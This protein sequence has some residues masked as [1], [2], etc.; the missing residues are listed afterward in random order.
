[1]ATTKIADIIKPAVFVPYVTQRT[2]ELSELVQSGIAENNPLFDKL[3]STGGTT[4]NMP[5][6]NDL[7]GDEELLSD[8]TALTPGN[9]T[10]AQ[11]VAVLLMRGRMWGVNDLAKALSGADPMK[12]IGDLVAAYR[13]RQLEKTLIQILT[14]VFASASMAGNLL[15]IS[16]GTGAAAVIS[17]SSILDAG[18]KLGDAGGQLTAMAIHS[19]TYNKLRKDNLIATVIPT[20]GTKPF[21]MYGDKKLI[22][23]DT[24]PVLSGV[25]TTYLFGNGAVAIGNGQA[26]VP[27]ETARDAAGGN[28]FLIYRHHTI[29][30]PRGV[31]WIGTPTGAS[32]ANGELNYSANWT[33]VYENKAIKMVQFKHKLA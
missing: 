8:T 25:Y 2:M 28:D 9:I 15:D 22:I 17:A 3:A 30:H 18:Q 12:A 31:K 1:M 7:T 5:F 14:G 19:D 33:R 27:V 16:G 13:A 24:L 4:I 29:L 26:P 11:D 20:D 23:D 6:F 32:P 10:S 21:S